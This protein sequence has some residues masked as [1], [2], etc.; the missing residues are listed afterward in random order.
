MR[1]S[2][3]PAIPSSLRSARSVGVA[4]AIASA[5]FFGGSGPFAK[6]LITAGLS[7]LQVAW[8][9]LAGGAVLMLPLLVRHLGVPRRSPGVLVG[10]GLF[11]VAGVQVCYFAAIATVPVGVA[12][13]IE[14]LGPVIVLGWIRFARRKPVSR[15]A[16]TG[17]VLAVVGLVFVV[18]LWSGLSFNPIGLLFGLG[19]ACCQATYFLVA[20]SADHVDPLALAGYG[21]LVGT[22]AVALIARPWEIDW[23][24]LAGDVVMAGH[25]VPAL[26]AVGWIV[27]FS[28]VLAYLTGIIAV[29]RLSPQVAGG[30]AFLEPVVAAVL[31]W[32]LLS[33][34]LGPMQLVGGALIL[35]GA[36][37]AQRAAP[38]AEPDL[39]PLQAADEG[40]R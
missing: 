36:Y 18:E 38:N 23:T 22:F 21:L 13:L 14:F 12:L 7:P 4:V 11:A 27:A 15:S 31:A 16:T 30:V 40:G 2:A 29:R 6:P 37:I 10:Y 34:E 24:L 20:D 3:D 9:R 19:A 1:T 35:V 17:V 39:G 33:E 25:Q 28:T 8:L 5:V 26:L 32:A